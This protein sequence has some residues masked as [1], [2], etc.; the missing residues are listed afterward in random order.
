MQFKVDLLKKMPPFSQLSE[1][2]L[3]RLMKSADMIRYK[4]NAV[5]YVAHDPSDRVFVICD[6]RVKLSRSSSEGREVVLD[7]LVAG[8]MFGEMVI[9]GESLRTHSAVAIDDSLLCALKRQ[10]VELVLQTNPDL[11]K[12]ILCHVGDRCAELELRLEDQIFLPV[13]QRLLLI[14]FRQAGRHG[15]RCVDGSV[16]IHL[17]QKDLAHLIGAS[18]ET[19]AELLATYKKKGVL[20]TGYRTIRLLDMDAISAALSAEGCDSRNLQSYAYCRAKTIRTLALK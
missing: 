14:L 16:I 11:A 20:H 3:N 15:E 12:Q 5:V 4:R 17:I 1:D 8:E 18:R 19:V 10:D 7:I 6:G 13:E 2:E 9:C